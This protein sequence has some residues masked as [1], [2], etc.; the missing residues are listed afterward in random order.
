MTSASQTDHPVVLIVDDEAMHARLIARWLATEDYETEI[1]EDGES[2]LR[3]IHRILPDVVCLD[4]NMPGIGGLETLRRLKNH[5]PRLPVI[6]LTAEDSVEAAVESMQAGAYGFLTKPVDKQ[7]LFTEVQQAVEHS[8]LSLRVAELERESGERE[9][10]RIH[11]QSDAM[12]PIFRQLD[13]VVASDVTVLLQGESG[14]GKELVAR[15][16]HD[17]SGRRDGPFLAVNCASIPEGLQESELFGHEKG[18]FTGAAQAKPGTFERADGGTLFLDEIA[19]LRPSLQASLLRVLQDSRFQRIGSQRIR[20]SN[21]RLIS[22]THKNL[23]DEVE[24][25]HFREDL[26]YRVAVFEMTLPPLRERAEDVP[27]LTRHFLDEFRSLEDK[28]ELDISQDALRALMSHDWP[29]NIR[30]LKNAVQRAV[31]AAGTMIRVRDLPQNVRKAAQDIGLPAFR[32]GLDETSSPAEIFGDDENVILP[33]QEVER[34]AIQRAYRVTEGNISKMSR[35]LGVS[36][37]TLYRK[38]D[39]YGIR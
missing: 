1:A 6:M 25:G 26:Y 27:L 28:P 38:L 20:E 4:L 21:F 23:L 16:I 37:A 8:V 10:D 13:R 9:Y 29:G 3:L 30:E 36:R 7:R 35:V 5:H 39:T 34:Q 32:A 2:C 17:K 24:A 18:A 22:A 12:K 14:T 11:S 31:V 19:E 15:E 33:L